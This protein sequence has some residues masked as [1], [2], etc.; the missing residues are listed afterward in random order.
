MAE[1][2]NKRLIL[3]DS[4]AIIHRAFHALPPFSTSKGEPTG[5]LYGLC[6]ML[7]KIIADLKPDYVVAAFDLPKPTFRHEAYKDYKAGRVKADESLVSQLIRSREVLEAFGIPIYDKEGYEADDIIGTIVRQVAVTPAKAGVQKSKEGEGALDSRLRGNDREI[8]VIIATGDMD[9]LQLVSDKKVQ[10]YTLKKGINDT[11][12]YDEER[13]KERFGFGPE[14]LADYKG[15]R[16]DASDNIKGI[17]GIGEKTATE[18]ITKFGSIEDIYRELRNKKS[19]IKTEIR[20]RVLELLEKGKEEAEFSKMLGTIKCDV[21]IDFQMPEKTWRE[22]VSEEKVKKLF[23]ELEFRGLPARF[24]TVLTGEKPPEEPKQIGMLF[25]EGGGSDDLR[26]AALMLWLL[27]SNL[28][29]PTVEDVL[30][31]SHTTTLTDAKKKLSADIKAANLTRVY[32]EIERPLIPVVG[33]MYER[34]IRVDTKFLKKLGTDYHAVLAGLEKKIHT[35]AGQEFN[36]ASPKQL[37][38]ILYVKMGLAPK[39]AKKTSTGALSTRE[40][41][42]EKLRDQSPIIGLILEYRE[43]AKL[44][45]T[46]IDTLPSLVAP[47]GRLHAKFL[48][49]G[50]T[51][52]RMSSEEPNLQNIP[53]QTDLGRKIRVGFVAEK[54]FKLLSLDYSQMELRIAAFIANEPRLIEIFKEGKDV[55]AAVASEV[56]GVP[57]EEVTKEMRRRAKVINFGVMYGMGV[58]SLRQALATDETRPNGGSVGRAPLSRE[59]AQ[60]FFDEYFLKF[61]GL[62][63]YLDKIKADAYK[64]GFTETFFGRRRYHEG[65]KSPV[66]FIRAAAERTAIN[67]PMQ[68][69][70]ADIIKLAMVQANA[71]IEKEK[72]GKDVF[73][74]LQVHDELVYELK[75]DLVKKVAPKLKEIMENTLSR[76]DTKGVPIVVDASVGDNWGEMEKLEG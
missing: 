39:R 63:E 68:G 71:W 36:I 48:Q 40:S 25:A 54:G 22:S 43:L 5:A 61:S 35:L 1:K 44:L 51:T 11:I 37:G 62:A 32:E 41:E 59:D 73:L 26:E 74:L 42:L 69:T 15:L 14:F 56:F 28:S 30:S 65:L 57:L 55:H 12:L 23:T 60:K 8:D 18:L 52:G 38:E 24:H 3:L 46:Y 75:E 64:R 45:G 21:P 7:I 9:A 66:Q 20:P 47:D 29:H 49:A 67:A 13:V 50:T 72:L 70:G 34:G 16:G 4:H 19:K 6:S 58:N 76:K 27:N 2:K 10:V 33:K 53:N 17:E 31:F